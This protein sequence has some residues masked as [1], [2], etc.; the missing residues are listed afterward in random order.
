[1]L[2]LVEKEAQYLP[3]FDEKKY[4]KI[5]LFWCVFW[6]WGKSGGKSGEK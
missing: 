3:I 5:G 4:Q 2:Y 1:M 6:W